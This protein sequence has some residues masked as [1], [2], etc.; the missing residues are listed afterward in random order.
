MRHKEFEA[1]E[2]S[3]EGAIFEGLNDADDLGQ[4]AGM[5]QPVV[6]NKETWLQNKNRQDYG[7]GLGSGHRRTDKEKQIESQLNR[8][9]ITLNFKA[10][11][12]ED[13]IEYMQKYTGIN[14]DIDTRALTEAAI[15]PKMPITSNLSEIRLVSALEVVLMKANLRW[16]IDKEV[17]RIS[18][19]KGVRSQMVRR[20]VPVA[21]LVVPV[22]D[23]VQSPT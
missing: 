8:Q 14:F 10:T 17:V 2:A 7:S 18:T 22:K 21:D 15:D 1:R 19:Q 6:F 16:V 12:L 23:S 9:T 20:T 11:P 13:V 5:K 3:K 4:Y